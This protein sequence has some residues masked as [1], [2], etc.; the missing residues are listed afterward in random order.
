MKLFDTAH[1]VTKITVETEP[2]EWREPHGVTN[3]VAHV[4]EQ[5]PGVVQHARLGASG[6][7]LVRGPVAVCLPLDLLFELAAQVDAKFTAAPD[8]ELPASDLEQ[9]AESK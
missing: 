6:L 2:G 4:D 5:S 3:S 7:Q 1:I 9:L 8:K